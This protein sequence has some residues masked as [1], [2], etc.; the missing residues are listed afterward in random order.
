MSSKSATLPPTQLPFVLDVYGTSL[1]TFILFFDRNF[2]LE[3][4]PL[5]SFSS[6][7]KG[8]ENEKAVGWYYGMVPSLPEM[9]EGS[10]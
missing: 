2:G 10:C 3:M 1:V 6:G 9:T 5:Q 4:G 8:F 7:C